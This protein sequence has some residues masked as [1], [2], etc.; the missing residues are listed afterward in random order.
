MA[1]IT[2]VDHVVYNDKST[3]PVSVGLTADGCAVQWQET[4]VNLTWEQMADVEYLY[5]QFEDVTV[6]TF[7]VIVEMLGKIYAYKDVYIA[8]LGTI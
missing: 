8:T 1:Q 2:I 4:S 7:K 6:R 5:T 3:T